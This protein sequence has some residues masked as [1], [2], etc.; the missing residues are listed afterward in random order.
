MKK[1]LIRSLMSLAIVA[2][3]GVGQAAIIG[4]YSPSA[5]TV[6]LFHFDE[7][8]GSNATAN[9]VMGKN[10]AIPVAV[11]DNTTVAQTALT[12]MLGA[13]AFTGFGNAGNVSATNRG[14]AYDANGSG[15]F[16]QDTTV[17]SPD[18]INLPGALGI[19][20]TSPAESFTLEAMINL[21]SIT[22]TRQIISLEA[23]PNSDAGRAMQFR[24]S[25]SQLQFVW[26]F[27]TT[28]LGVAIPTTG[29]DAF[30]AN[31]WYHVAFSHDAATN[32]NQLYWT[33]V[34]STRTAAATLGSP[35]VNPTGLDNLANKN[36]I[37]AFGNY[38]SN[39][40]WSNGLNGLLDEVRISNAALGSND[41]IFSSVPEP[42][43]M[44]IAAVAMISG[45]AV[46]RRRTK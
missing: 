4:P 44:L 18:R 33:K 2:V 8:S 24:I 23:S 15:G 20:T 9:A 16:S 29:D 12:T 19:T 17:A 46:H 42:S 21:P 37:L 30:V 28:T 34:D 14:F 11:A 43:T 39:G 45:F 7:A 32:S 41:F 40:A 3:T 1:N 6:H 13:T 27:T 22:G 31:Q 25:S 38:D 5:S 10:N 26:V 36:G 35:F